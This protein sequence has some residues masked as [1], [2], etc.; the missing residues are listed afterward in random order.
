MHT[1][2]FTHMHPCIKMCTYIT[3][4]VSRALYSLTYIDLTLVL[5]RRPHGPVNKQPHMCWLRLSK[6]ASVPWQ[7]K[8][9]EA[10][11]LHRG[12]PEQSGLTW[13]FQYFLVVPGVPPWSLLSRDAA[14]PEQLLGT[15]ARVFFMCVPFQA[16]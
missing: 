3:Q 14:R 4:L 13:M 5:I 15:L 16:M 11:K 1:C 2:G 8:A 7:W 12:G 9:K 6:G 10:C